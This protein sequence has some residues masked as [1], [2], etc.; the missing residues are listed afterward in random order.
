MSL[1]MQGAKM[2]VLSDLAAQARQNGEL[3]SAAAIER[4]RQAE[5]EEFRELA[6]RRHAR[7]H[8]H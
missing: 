7:R 5:L 8:P 3:E 4:V 1:L 2:K 6:R